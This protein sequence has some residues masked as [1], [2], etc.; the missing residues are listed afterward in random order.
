M[1]RITVKGSTKCVSGP[2]S[3]LRLSLHWHRLQEPIIRTAVDSWEHVLAVIRERTNP[4]EGREIE[5]RRRPS[6][7]RQFSQDC[8][9]TTHDALSDMLEEQLNILQ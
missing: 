9:T 2:D 3:H 7:D 1:F 6:G 8:L 4:G 5:A